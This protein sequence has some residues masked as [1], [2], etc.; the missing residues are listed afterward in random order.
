MLSTEE[1]EANNPKE[2]I[3][4]VKIPKKQIIVDDICVSFNSDDFKHISK[5]NYWYDDN[6]MDAIC[7]LININK[8][9]EN[10]FFEKIPVVIENEENTIIPNIMDASEPM[11]G[12]E[13]VY[14][15]QVQ[16]FIGNQGFGHF[17]HMVIHKEEKKLILVETCPR[18]IKLAQYKY[19]RM[20]SIVLQKIG[21]V[22]TEE[23]QT[24]KNIEFKTSNRKR[25]SNT[26]S[27]E[28][29]CLKHFGLRVP[30]EVK[31]TCGPVAI[32]ALEFTC[33]GGVNWSQFV[34]DTKLGKVQQQVVNFFKNMLLKHLQDM[35][36]KKTI[37]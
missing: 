26:D 16:E 29:W 21:W 32:K 5:E 35:T 11:M 24:M 3:T 6:V 23:S 20:F 7:G 15:R 30:K 18:D 19:K 27:N 12:N 34:K 25:K 1:V 13:N 9:Q 10:M 33:K 17:L 31:P 14:C 8:N 28:K 22:D 4:Q 37:G 36:K 2:M